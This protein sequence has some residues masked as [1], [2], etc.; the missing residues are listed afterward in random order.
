MTTVHQNHAKAHE[1]AKLKANA[2]GRPVT[3]CRVGQLWYVFTPEET[4]PEGP[5]E[6]VEEVFPDLPPT[7][8][9]WPVE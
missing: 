1:K 5:P 6:E 9:G 7:E 4:M 2:E 3:I 8:G